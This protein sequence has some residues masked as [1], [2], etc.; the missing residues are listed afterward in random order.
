MIREKIDVEV[1]IKEAK[2][3][4]GGRDNSQTTF[5]QLG[6]CESKQTVMEKKSAQKGTD[7]M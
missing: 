3:I 2:C 5:V 6:S 4:N 1:D 7:I